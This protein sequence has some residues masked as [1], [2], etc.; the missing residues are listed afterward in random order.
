MGVV[1]RFLATFLTWVLPGL[2]HLYL[3]RRGKALY[4]FALVGG[5]FVV[6]MAFA[7][8]HNVSIERHPYFSIAYALAGGPTALALAVT[9]K[10]PVES[11]VNPDLGCLLSAVAGLLNVLVMIDAYTIAEES[12]SR[13][14]GSAASPAVGAS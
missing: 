5:L 7:D 11:D 3:G 13:G 6:G 9:A 12:G 1:R 2:G 14:V 10:I 4:F 8:F